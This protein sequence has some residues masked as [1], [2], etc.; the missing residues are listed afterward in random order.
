MNNIITNI[1]TIID[2]STLT[3]N[4][5]VSNIVQTNILAPIIPSGNLVCCHDLVFDLPFERCC[6]RRKKCCL[7]KLLNLNGSCNCFSISQFNCRNKN[8]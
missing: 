1:S 7:C 8:F 4:I 6:I 5:F 2:N 3:P